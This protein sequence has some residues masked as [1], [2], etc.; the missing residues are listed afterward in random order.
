MIDLLRARRWA[1]PDAGVL[2]FGGDSSSSQETKNIDGRVVGGD[3]SQNISVAGNSGTTSV[4]ITDRGAV[5]DSLQLAMR[6]VEQANAITTATI[7]QNAGLLDN[8]LH[9]V[10][11]QQQQFTSAL[12]NLKGNDV[13][14]LVIVGVSVVGLAAVMLFKKG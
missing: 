6:G 4:E 10:S 5:H 1:L 11:T 3:N 9:T 8:A 12:E 7:N 14:T 2:C 13:R